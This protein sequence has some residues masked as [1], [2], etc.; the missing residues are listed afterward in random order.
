M[1]LERIYREI[2]RRSEKH[3]ND[4]KTLVRQPSISPENV[5]IEEV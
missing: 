2:D 3:L 5:G 1:Q 4:L